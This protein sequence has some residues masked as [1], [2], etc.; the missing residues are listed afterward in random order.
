MALNPH[1]QCNPG[2]MSLSTEINIHPGFNEGLDCL[3]DVT[4]VVG[5]IT[6]IYPGKL[7]RAYRVT[8]YYR[9][10]CKNSTNSF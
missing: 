2:V 8:E 9:C 4:L 1:V 3:L 6:R 10:S 5:H 7:Q